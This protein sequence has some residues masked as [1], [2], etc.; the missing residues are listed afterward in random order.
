MRIIK[1]ITSTGF[2]GKKKTNKKYYY[3]N[4]DVKC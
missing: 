2:E 1:K 4:M 3:V